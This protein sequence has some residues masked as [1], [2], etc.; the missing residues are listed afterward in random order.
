MATLYVGAEQTYKTI[1]EAVAAAAAGDTVIVKGSEYALTDERV[2]VDKSLTLSAE[3]D[4]TMRGMNIGGKDFDIVID[5]I[6]DE[7]YE[8]NCFD[9]PFFTFL[10][11]TI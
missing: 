2:R 10:A 9:E 3:G 11:E 5:G 4:V 1:A 8:N 7:W 6:F